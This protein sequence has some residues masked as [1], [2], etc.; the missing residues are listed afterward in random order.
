VGAANDKDT[1]IL[2]AVTVRPF[3]GESLRAAIHTQDVIVVEP[4]LA[5][6]SAADI[7]AALD[8]IPARLL[9][10]GVPRMEHRHYGTARE[11]DKAHRLDVEGIRSHIADF[12]K[13]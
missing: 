13:H 9:N 10:I 8:G 3:D 5:G 2:Y 6:T 12:L 7:C 4:Y 11:H 1:T